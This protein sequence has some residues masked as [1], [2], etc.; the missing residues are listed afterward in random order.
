M[1]NQQ[2]INAVKGGHRV[3]LMIN[4]IL[5][6]ATNVIVNKN[7]ITAFLPNMLKKT[8]IEML[9]GTTGK[10][11]WDWTLVNTNGKVETANYF[12]D[13]G[14]CSLLSG[15]ADMK[16]FIDSREWNMVLDVGP[17]SVNIGSKE[18]LANDIKVIGFWSFFDGNI[19]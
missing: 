3:K 18:Q 15:A 17:S 12:I 1:L 2:L 7:V 10:W 14:Q 9:E 4:N 5:S 6:Q 8:S 19:Y 16:W 11:Q 13:E